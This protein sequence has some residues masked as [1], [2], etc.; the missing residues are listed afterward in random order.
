M[1]QKLAGPVKGITDPIFNTFASAGACA[2]GAAHAEIAMIS[3]A[4]TTEV[5]ILYFPDIIPLINP[6]ELFISTGIIPS[7]YN[8]D[9]NYFFTILILV[10]WIWQSPRP[11]AAF[12][13]FSPWGLQASHRETRR[14]WVQHRLPASLYTG[15]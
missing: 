14:T 1:P 10:I 3:I 13:G 15:L 9:V 12:S 7:R 5:N 6:F 8:P 11:L 4:S 2:A